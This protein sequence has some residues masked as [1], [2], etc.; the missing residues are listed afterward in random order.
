MACRDAGLIVKAAVERRLAAT[1]LPQR[2]VDLTTVMLEHTHS[3]ESD[4]WK[5]LVDETRVEQVN[6][7]HRG[8]AYCA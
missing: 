4:R 6:R 7:G 8:R 5:E 3:R 1:G 2:D